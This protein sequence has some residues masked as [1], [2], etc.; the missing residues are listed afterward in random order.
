[1]LFL[2]CIICN[3][4]NNVQQIEGIV[5]LKLSAA[6]PR[7]IAHVG[8]ALSTELRINILE[9]LQHRKMN[10]IE[11]AA[12]LDTSNSTIAANIRI[13]EES[14]LVQTE[15]QPAKRGSEKICSVVYNDIY[16]NLR[17]TADIPDAEDFYVC[18]MPVGM[19]SNCITSPTC[20]MADEFG[21]IGDQDDPSAFYLPERSKARTIWLSG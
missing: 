13:L 15:F 14:G 19:F 1:M 9:L 3:I 17:A 21:Y 12:A 8:T 11:I 10:V 7:Q 4:P 5:M 20:G 2:L 6:D 18:E 16:I